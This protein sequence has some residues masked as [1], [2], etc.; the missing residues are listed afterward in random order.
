MIKNVLES[1]GG[2]GLYGLTSMLLFFLVFVGTI[3]WVI[4]LK[5]NYI[6]RMKKLPL[7]PDETP[8][9][10]GDSHA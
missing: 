5:R 3:V 4:R 10:N 8:P 6:Q 2:I 7:E 9:Q 1:I